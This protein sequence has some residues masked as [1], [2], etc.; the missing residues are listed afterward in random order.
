MEKLKDKIEASKQ[1]YDF[2]FIKTTLASTQNEKK[3]LTEAQIKS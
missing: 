3:Y 1:Q 2:K